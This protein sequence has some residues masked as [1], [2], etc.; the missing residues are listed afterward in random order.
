M[1]LKPQS[2]LVTGLKTTCS[3]LALTA[4]A[5][6]FRNESTHRVPNRHGSGIYP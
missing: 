6:P 1:L 2:P 4:C 3:V 5:K